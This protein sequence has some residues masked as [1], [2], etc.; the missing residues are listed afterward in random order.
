MIEYCRHFILDEIV[1]SCD[2]I[3]GI[4]KFVHLPDIMKQVR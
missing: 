1:E 4:D 2:F 3:S